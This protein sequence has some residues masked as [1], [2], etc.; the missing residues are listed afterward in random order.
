MI[1][2]STMDLKLI[3]ENQIEVKGRC[4]GNDKDKNK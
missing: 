2:H 1:M 3:Q 4:R